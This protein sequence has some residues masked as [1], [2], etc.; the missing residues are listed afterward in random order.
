MLKYKLPLFNKVGYSFIIIGVLLCFG[1]SPSKFSFIKTPTITYRKEL[2][3]NIRGQWQ[4]LDIVKD[5]LAGTSLFRAY[6][7]IIKNKKGKEIIVA[8]IDTDIDINHED[9]KEAIWIN[10][11]KFRIM[12]LMTIRMVI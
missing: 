12:E 3:I 11:R 6:E 9:L 4:H 2:P 10:K 5:T 8:V 1:C 7:D